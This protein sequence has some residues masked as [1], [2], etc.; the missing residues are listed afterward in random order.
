MSDDITVFIS[1]EHH[2]NAPIELGPEDSGSNGF[3]VVYTAAP[4]EHPVITG[5][6]RVTG[7]SL[8]DKGRNLWSAPAPAGLENT[9]ALFVNGNIANRTRGRLLQF[10]AKGSASE[11]AS[12]PD[13]TR[14]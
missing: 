6:Y 9:F 1:G 8:A 2:V 5:G 3:N 4:G 14:A 12:A 11:T 10:F 13:A 7:W